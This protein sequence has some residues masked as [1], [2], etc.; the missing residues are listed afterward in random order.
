MYEVEA[1]LNYLLTNKSAGS[2]R[3]TS[4][5]FK[6]ACSRL[7]TLLSNAI[8]SVGEERSRVNKIHH[9]GEKRL[10]FLEGETSF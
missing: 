4:V 10:P 8:R 3:L 5:H 1:A 6:L 7:V 9:L 2:D